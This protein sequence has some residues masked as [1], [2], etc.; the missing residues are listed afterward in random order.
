MSLSARGS[1]YGE[2]REQ[3]EQERSPDAETDDRI[4][5]VRAPAR[6]ARII[7]AL[8]REAVDGNANAGRE[9]RAWLAEYPPQ[10]TEL[11]IEA[12]DRQLRQRIV[13]RLVAEIEA[14]DAANEE[15]A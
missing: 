3:F 12:M 15:N 10:D 6:V 7:T 4:F 9:L 1:P 5:I 8:E 13:A 2:Q 11:S 14:K